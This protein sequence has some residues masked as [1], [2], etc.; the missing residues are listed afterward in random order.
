MGR[1]ETGEPGEGGERGNCRGKDGTRIA[2]APGASE[3]AVSQWM[4]AGREQGTEGLP[5]T[6]AKGPRQRLSKEQ[7]EQLPGLADSAS[8][9]PRVSRSSPGEWASGS[10]DQ[11]ALW[12]EAPLHPAPMRQLFK[13]V[14]YST[15]QPTEQAIDVWKNERWPELRE[16]RQAGRAIHFAAGAGSADTRSSSGS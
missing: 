12:G 10:L 13:E 4:K 9:G 15:R 14:K 7:R 3:R 11:K 2:Q 8:P 6:G 16:A 5:G 1:E